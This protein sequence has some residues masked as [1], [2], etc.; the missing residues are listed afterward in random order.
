[1]FSPLIIITGGSTNSNVR[2]QHIIHAIEIKAPTRPCMA[3]QI[4]FRLFQTIR[5]VYR[6]FRVYNQ[7]NVRSVAA[8]VT[9]IPRA[10]PSRPLSIDPYTRARVR[11]TLTSVVD[12]DVGPNKV[13]PRSAYRDGRDLF[14]FVEYTHT[15]TQEEERV[16]PTERNRCNGRVFRKRRFR[17]CLRCFTP[18]EVPHTSGDAIRSNYDEQI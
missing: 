8:T 11:F 9:T 6:V 2:R 17:P 1:V 18:N 14:V 10:S 3:K 16:R 7:L 12:A 4:F 5:G 15:H 13:S